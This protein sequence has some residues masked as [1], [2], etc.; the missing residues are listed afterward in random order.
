MCHMGYICRSSQGEK[1]LLQR[2][3]EPLGQ[4]ESLI[5]NVGLVVWWHGKGLAKQYVLIEYIPV[6]QVGRFGWL[7][8]I[9]R[10]DKAA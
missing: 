6:G 5:F 1:R 4:G 7:L 9:V 3:C 8:L 2:G 10:I